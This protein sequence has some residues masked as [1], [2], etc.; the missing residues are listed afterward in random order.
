MPQ[1]CHSYLV[2]SESLWFWRHPNE[3]YCLVDT[4]AGMFLVVP[5]HFVKVAVIPSDTLGNAGLPLQIVGSCI[6]Y[7][8]IETANL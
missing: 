1:L 3:I 7:P 2:Q 4:T 5:F 8:L 6:T